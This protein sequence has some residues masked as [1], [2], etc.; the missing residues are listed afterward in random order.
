MIPEEAAPD[1]LRQ[2]GLDFGPADAQVPGDPGHAA[3]AAEDRQ[4]D[5]LL[6][7]GAASPVR[8]M[9][10]QGVEFRGRGLGP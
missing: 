4:A 8:D 3:V 2:G 6:H 9:D 5:G 7:A 1:Q 10:R